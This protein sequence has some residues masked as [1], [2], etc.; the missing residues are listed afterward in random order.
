ML[1]IN[2]ACTF[3]N[4]AIGWGPILEDFEKVVNVDLELNKEETLDYCS[5][6]ENEYETFDYYYKKGEG[7]EY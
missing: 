2:Y 6:E 7:S 1:S 4:T 5:D 3:G